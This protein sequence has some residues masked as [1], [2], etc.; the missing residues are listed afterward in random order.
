MSQPD[1]ETVRR[2]AQLYRSQIRSSP[3]VHG[4]KE[5]DMNIMRVLGRTGDTE[6][7]WNP[8]T[9]EGL[10]SARR[11]FEEKMRRGYLAF[12]EGPNGEGSNLIR[13]FDPQAGSI[14]L[15]PRLVGG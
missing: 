7:K 15:A 5:R 13:N 6:V 11:V 4:K 3:E 14:I 9:G 10:Q 12:V 8:D 1:G 2:P